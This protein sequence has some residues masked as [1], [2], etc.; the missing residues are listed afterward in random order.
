[1]W[2]NCKYGLMRGNRTSLHGRL[3]TGTK[4]ETADIDKDRPNER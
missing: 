3:Y 2:E 1:M 4:L